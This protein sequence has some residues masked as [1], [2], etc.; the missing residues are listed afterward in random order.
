MGF[1]MKNGLYSVTTKG[2]DGVRWPPGGV[3]I[4]SSS[5]FDSERRYGSDF[6][7]SDLGP[8]YG[9]LLMGRSIKLLPENAERWRF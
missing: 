3:F 1:R 7:Q 8:D 5:R 9:L 6:A 2:F 4:P